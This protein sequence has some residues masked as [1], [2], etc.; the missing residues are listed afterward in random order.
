M[1]AP[2]N[3][4][5]LR[6][7]S[8]SCKAEM[9]H[10]LHFL[11]L[12]PQ[13]AKQAVP[14]TKAEVWC[15]NQA[16]LSSSAGTEGHSAAMESRRGRSCCTETPQQ[17]HCRGTEELQ[18]VDHTVQKELGSFRKRSSFSAAYFFPQSR[19]K[20]T[21]CLQ[22]MSLLFLPRSSSTTSN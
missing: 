21:F 2:I 8:A 5:P 12:N 16:T 19:S 22:Q 11:A 14:Q 17:S 18:S 15:H 6:R 9:K 1:F 20:T 4:S 3:P 13:L 7:A 10:H